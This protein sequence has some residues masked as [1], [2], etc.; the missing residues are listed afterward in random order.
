LGLG[1]WVF[2]V[3]LWLLGLGFWVQV[4]GFRIT[5]FGFWVSGFGFRQ[6]QNLFFRRLLEGVLEGHDALLEHLH[7]FLQR[8]LMRCVNM[9][10]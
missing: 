8:H 5:G 10:F 2:G 7:V 3:G 6:P 1:F 4:P 9:N